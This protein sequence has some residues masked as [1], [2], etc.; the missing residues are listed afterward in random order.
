M[1]WT[2]NTVPVSVGSE[3]FETFEG[4]KSVFRIKGVG[5]FGPVS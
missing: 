1:R 3:A 5:E 4:P 2:T